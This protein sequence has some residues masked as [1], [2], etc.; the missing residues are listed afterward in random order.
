MIGSD[1]AM[2]LENEFSEREI[3]EVIRGCGG[4]K[5]LARMD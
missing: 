3:V 5:P 1:D 4:I 2:A